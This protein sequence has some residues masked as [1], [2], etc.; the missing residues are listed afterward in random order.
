MLIL[1]CHQ[2]LSSPSLLPPASTTRQNEDWRQEEYFFKGMFF[3][4]DRL[5]ARVWLILEPGIKLVLVADQVGSVST[6]EVHSSKALKRETLQIS[7]QRH[8]HNMGSMCK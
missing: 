2:R 8:H 5:V 3:K 7:I 6:P 1:T 4:S